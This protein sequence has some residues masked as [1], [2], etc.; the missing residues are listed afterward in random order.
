MKAFKSM[1]AQGGKILILIL[2]SLLISGCGKSEVINNEIEQKTMEIPKQNPLTINSAGGEITLKDLASQ[3]SGAVIKTNFGDIR[4]KFYREESPLTVNNFMNLA[5]NGF[6]NKTKFHRVISDFMI[7]GGCPNSKDDNWDDDGTGGP[8]YSF[9][10]E[11]N[12]H[13]LVRGSL[14][15]ANAGPNTNGSQ[16]FI[17][18]APATNWLDGK[19]TNFGEVVEGMDTVDKIE[20]VEKNERDHPTKD[21]IIEGVELVK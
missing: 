5:E 6:Y 20:A 11:I 4:V 19:H 17:V 9:K 3:Y 2:F 14:A 12:N 16:F 21:V 13:K 10:D 15:M 8:G 7:Q 1:S 18:T